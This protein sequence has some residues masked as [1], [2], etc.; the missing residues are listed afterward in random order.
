MIRYS[1]YVPEVPNSSVPAAWS[2]D[3]WL[4][5]PVAGCRSAGVPQ[6]VVEF[7]TSTTSFNAGHG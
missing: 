3:S 7:G 4:A 2:Y 6:A 1:V 5:L